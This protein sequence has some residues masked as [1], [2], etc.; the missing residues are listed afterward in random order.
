M[1]CKCLCDDFG[2]NCGQALWM[3]TAVL[4]LI[5]TQTCI[6]RK[7]VHILGLF[8]SLNQKVYIPFLFLIA[9]SNFRLKAD[10]QLVKEVYSAAK[11]FKMDRVKQVRI[12]IAS[13]SLY[14]STFSSENDF[15]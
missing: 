9:C 1:H 12:I 11:R 8:N 2:V 15:C 10:Q 4:D 5:K 3:Y 6:I 7:M 14:I 13:P